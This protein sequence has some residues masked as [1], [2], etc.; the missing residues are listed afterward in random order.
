M[1]DALIT[2]AN[3]ERK[4]RVPAVAAPVLRAWVDQALAT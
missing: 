1:S 3:C 4:N 2:C